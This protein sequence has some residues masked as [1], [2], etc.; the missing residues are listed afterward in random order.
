MKNFIKIAF[1]SLVC[2]FGAAFTIIAYHNDIG[3][4]G[5]FS[6]LYE[7]ILGYVPE[8]AGGL[9]IAYSIGLFVGIVLFFNHFGG[10]KLTKEPTPLQVEMEQ[11]EEQ[12][13]NALRNMNE[14]TGGKK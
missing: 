11:Y 2:F 7:L 10:V 12:V 14:K 1:V 5:V 4:T 9:E 3:I 13:K 6:G 8:K